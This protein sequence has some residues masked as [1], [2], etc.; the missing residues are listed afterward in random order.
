MSMALAGPQSA[1]AA[2]KRIA[3]LKSFTGDRRRSKDMMG[4]LAGRAVRE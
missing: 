4:L 3:A 1:I 2:Q